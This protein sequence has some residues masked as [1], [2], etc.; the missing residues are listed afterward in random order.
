MRGDGTFDDIAADLRL[1][2]AD[3]CSSAAFADFDNDGDAD[4][5]IGRTLKPSRFLVNENGRFVDRSQALPSAALPYFVASISPADFNGDGLIDVYLSTYVHDDTAERLREVLKLLPED[6]GTEILRRRKLGHRFH[7]HAGP[8]N[9][10]LVNRGSG[11]F[12]IAPQSE[13]LAVWRNTFQSTWSDFD[14]DGDA[15][16]YA[17]NDFAPNN[18]FR[19]DGGNFSE[20]TEQTG[21]ADIGFGM[22]VSWGDFDNDGRHDLY[23]CNMFSKAGNRIMSQIPHLDPRIGVLGRWQFA[24]PQPGWQL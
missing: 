20:V 18:M 16:L 24:V 3:N 11:R 4:V 2:L 13:Q 19:N 21:T 14:N 5:F 17:A 10:L 23:V 6:Q 7:D 15:D 8:P 22:G 9:V 1:D 12:E